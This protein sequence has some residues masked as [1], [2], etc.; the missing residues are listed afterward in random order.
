MELDFMDKKQLTLFD[1]DMTRYRLYLDQVQPT[2]LPDAATQADLRSYA[3]KLR[4]RLRLIK[5][6][7]HPDIEARRASIDGFEILVAGKLASAGQAARPA[8][9]RPPQP[10]ARQRP[11][12][13][14]T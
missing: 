3:G 10:P 1:K 12:R 9:V 5:Q 8:P 4:D 11:P 7:N 2:Q 14:K 13:P 6:P